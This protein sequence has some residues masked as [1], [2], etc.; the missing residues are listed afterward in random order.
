MQRKENKLVKTIVEAIQ[1][2]KGQNVVVVDFKKIT[3]FICS[4]FVICQ[5][6]SRPQVDAIAR[7]IGEYTFEKTG[8]K[9]FAVSGESNALWI[10]IDYGDIMVHVFEPETR[11]FYDLEHL[12]EDATLTTIPDIQ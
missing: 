6:N 5:G 8:E 11:K 12:W 9:P 3:D 4:Y 7:N 1:D 10:A 2:K